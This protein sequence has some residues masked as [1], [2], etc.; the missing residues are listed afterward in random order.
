MVSKVQRFLRLRSGRAEG[1][2]RYPTSRV[3]AVAVRSLVRTIRQESCLRRR[4]VLTLRRI[5]L[6]SLQ[7]VSR[8][9]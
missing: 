7:G 1:S 2:P 8:A 3:I 9:M 6:F 4:I 5:V